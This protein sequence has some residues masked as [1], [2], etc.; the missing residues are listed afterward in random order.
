MHDTTIAYIS[1][2]D[3]KNEIRHYAC[4]LSSYWCI[5]VCCSSVVCSFMAYP[6]SAWLA[7]LFYGS[8]KWKM[9]LY[10]FLN[11]SFQTMRLLC[12]FVQ[13]SNNTP[14]TGSTQVS[15]NTIR[16]RDAILTCA[17]KPIWVSLIYRTE[18]TTKKCK[19]RKKTKSR[20]HIC[21]EITV[22]SPGKIIIRLCR[23]LLA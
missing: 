22:N 23:P 19:N 13:F 5:F 7:C 9:T 16:E 14:G 10:W 18:P 4:A 2:C 20:K 17:R 6:C 15:Y 3:C 8:G 1:N 11:K 21:P 12:C